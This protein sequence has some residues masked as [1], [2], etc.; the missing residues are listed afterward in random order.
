M[1]S[2]PRNPQ[3][4]SMKARHYTNPDTMALPPPLLELSGHIFSDFFS[5]ASIEVLFFL[6]AR[7]LPHP[8]PS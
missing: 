2:N 6:V 8:R 5:G 3:P 4:R 7:P 1:T